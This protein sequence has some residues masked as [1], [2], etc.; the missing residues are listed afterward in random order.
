MKDDF[1]AWVTTPGAK[2]QQRDADNKRRIFYVDNDESKLSHGYHQ[3]L[4]QY[5]GAWELLGR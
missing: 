5:V 3:K 2:G 4:A 1:H